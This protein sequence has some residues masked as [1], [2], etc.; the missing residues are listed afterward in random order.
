MEIFLFFL[1]SQ[2]VFLFHLFS[3]GGKKSSFL[4]YPL[5]Q[6]VSR[7]YLRTLSFFQK[8]YS[9]SF[10]FCTYKPKLGWH[11]AEVAA[12]GLN[13]DIPPKKC[14]IFKHSAPS[15]KIFTKL[16]ESNLTEPKTMQR[17]LILSFSF[18]LFLVNRLA[19]S[20]LVCQNCSH[21]KKFLS[22]NFRKRD[23]KRN[24]DESGKLKW[25]KTWLW[26]F[27]CVSC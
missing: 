14:Q 11:S 6:S 9:L 26:Y 5:F 15:D 10:F 24:W 12:P 16:N 17:N 21:T 3:D 13:L 25:K 19:S 1:Y 7:S 18:F 27:N 4:R 8:I 23:L 20:F 22:F 2:F